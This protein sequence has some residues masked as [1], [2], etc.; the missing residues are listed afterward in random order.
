MSLLAIALI[1]FSINIIG[2]LIWYTI[3]GYINFRRRAVF[4]L[5]ARLILWPLNKGTFE[6]I[7]SACKLNTM[8][9]VFIFVGMPVLLCY[10]I[11][12]AISIT[13]CGIGKV[14]SNTFSDFVFSKEERAQIAVGTLELQNKSGY[15]VNMKGKIE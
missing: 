13:C 3:P 12:R 8:T 14:L 6:E 11:L 9:A 4:N 5:P 2:T 1:Y 7:N 15:S 10:T